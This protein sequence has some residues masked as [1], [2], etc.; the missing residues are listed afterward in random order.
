MVNR[1]SELAD[2]LDDESL[3]LWLK[4]ALKTKREEI[5]DALEAGQSFT[6]PPGP[7]GEVVEIAPKAV[8]AVA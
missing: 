8:A 1:L 3:P 2:F 4:E 5:N 7:N 6:L